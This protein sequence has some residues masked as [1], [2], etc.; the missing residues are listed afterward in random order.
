MVTVTTIDLITGKL[1][2]RTC[3][4]GDVQALAASVVRRVIL[5]SGT[6]VDEGPTDKA[7]S[8]IYASDKHMKVAFARIETGMAAGPLV[9]Q[10]I[11]YGVVVKLP[12]KQAASYQ[13][14]KTVTNLKAFVVERA[15]A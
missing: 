5:I 2:P 7:L 8:A 15:T 3:A 12:R 4:K 1:E 10:G 13:S 14:S 6:D 9:V 11:P